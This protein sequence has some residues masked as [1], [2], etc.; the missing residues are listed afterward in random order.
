MLSGCL[1]GFSEVETEELQFGEQCV[2]THRQ[3]VYFVKMRMVSSSPA[4]RTGTNIKWGMA[5]INF[6]ILQ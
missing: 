1:A 4:A 6:K 5:K 3:L 2:S